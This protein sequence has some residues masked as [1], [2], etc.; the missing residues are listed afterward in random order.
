M[1]VSTLHTSTVG[2]IRNINPNHT[3][4]KFN[5]VYDN[6]F[7]T[8]HSTESLPPSKWTDLIVFD[9]FCSNFD[10]SYFFPE[11]AGA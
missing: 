9:R 10:D 1:G 4:P 5:V 11:V 2:L 6:I 7:L 3:S 8:V